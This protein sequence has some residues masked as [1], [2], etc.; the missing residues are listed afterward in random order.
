MT[1][2]LPTIFFWQLLGFSDLKAKCCARNIAQRYLLQN[3]VRLKEDE[4]EDEGE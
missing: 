1:C 4:E 2:G 3:K